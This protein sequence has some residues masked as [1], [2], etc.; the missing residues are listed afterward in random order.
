MRGSRE[1][2]GAGRRRLSRNVSV[3]VMY[4]S[5]KKLE[6]NEWVKEEMKSKQ[7]SMT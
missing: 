3:A 2:R 6:L 5:L 1:T 7:K 4:E